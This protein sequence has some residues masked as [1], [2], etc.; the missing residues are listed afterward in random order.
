RPQF[1]GIVETRAADARLGGK[2]GRVAAVDPASLGTLIKPQLSSGS[3]GDLRAGTA[4]VTGRSPASGTITL[5][6]GGR[7]ATFRVVG[8]TTSSLPGGGP[9]DALITW[10]DLAALAGPG[11]DDA[12]MVKA[13][14]GVSPTAS[15]DAL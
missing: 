13:A 2:D 12:V 6:V 10:D 7:S 9:V 8:T 1:A 3:L 11:D 14:P 5:A 15:R 4:I